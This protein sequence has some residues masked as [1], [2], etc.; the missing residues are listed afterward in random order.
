M[1]RRIADIGLHVYIFQLVAGS[2]Y[3]TPE[4]FASDFFSP[5]SQFMAMHLL[6]IIGKENYPI[7]LFDETWNVLK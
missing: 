5:V 7:C 4:S 1:Y 3:L 6:Q 2:G